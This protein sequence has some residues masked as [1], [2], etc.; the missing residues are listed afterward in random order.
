MNHTIPVNN[1]LEKIGNH[2]GHA[3]PVSQDPIDAALHEYDV[4]SIGESYFKKRR[5]KAKAEMLL[6][7]SET[8][9]DTLNT[10]ITNTKKTGVTG[11]I[12][13]TEGAF[14]QLNA[15]IKNGASFLD[16]AVLAVELKKKFPSADVDAA[17]EKARKKRSPSTVY[18]VVEV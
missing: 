6:L 3:A 15:Q 11:N 7:I 16:E 1:A 8:A 14:Y 5:E 17:F 4:C 2:N 12:K 13:V 10:A 18:T 9:N